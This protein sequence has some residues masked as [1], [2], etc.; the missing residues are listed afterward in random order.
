MPALQSLECVV[1][2]LQ[3]HERGQLASAY[4]DVHQE[5]QGLQTASLGQPGQ[6]LLEKSLLPVAIK[7]C[8]IPLIQ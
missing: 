6:C 3:N 2:A 1:P 7:H 8:F 4:A 5:C